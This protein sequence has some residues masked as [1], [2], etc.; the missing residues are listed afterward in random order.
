MAWAIITIYT[1][2]CAKMDTQQLLKTSKFYSRCKKI[3]IEKTLGGVGTTTSPKVKSDYT[4]LSP[5]CHIPN[6]VSPEYLIEI[7]LIIEKSLDLRNTNI[8]DKKI[9]V[10]L[11]R[12]FPTHFCAPLAIASRPTFGSRPTVLA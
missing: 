4:L 11:F 9:R 5:N 2:K 7:Y 6:I 8:N 10:G 12:K 1:S 3:D